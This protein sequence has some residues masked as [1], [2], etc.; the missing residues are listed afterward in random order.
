MPLALT[1]GAAGLMFGVIMDLSVWV[2]YGGQQTAGQFLAISATSLPFNLAH[3]IGNVVFCLAFGPVLVRALLRYR[4]R[5]DVSWTDAPALAAPVAALAVAVLIA[6]AAL[7]PAGA[8]AAPAGT[9]PADALPPERAERRRRL[10]DRA[11]HAVERG[12][13]VVERDRAGRGRLR[14][15]QRPPLGALR[16]VAAA[17]LRLALALGRGPRAH[18]A[19]AR[20]RR[21][22]AAHRRAVGASARGHRA[23]TGPSAGS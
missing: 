7:A 13:D 8:R 20:R 22:L 5:L 16:R 9:L 10:G 11:A 6:G 17:P 18:G 1:C 15:A 12:A 14:P 2:T 21:P 19:G 3:A 23:P 4:A